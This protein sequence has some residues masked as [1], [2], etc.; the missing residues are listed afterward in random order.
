MT[1]QIVWTLGTHRG[2]SPYAL[3]LL[4]AQADIARRQAADAKADRDA[5]RT[6]TKV[7]RLR[8]YELLP[9]DPAHD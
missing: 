9:V 6:E 4:E 2:Y 5:G 3:P 8:V 7:E 1:Y